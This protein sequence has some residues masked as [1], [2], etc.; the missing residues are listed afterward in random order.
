M[1]AI[2]LTFP[3]GRFHAT[4]WSRHVNEGAPEWPPSPWRLLRSFVAVW[5]RKLDDQLDEATVCTLL[6]KLSAPPVF[7]LPQAVPAHTRHYMPLYDG[8]RTLVFDSFLAIGKEEKILVAWSDVSLESEEAEA[9]S[10]LLENLG[11]LGRAESWCSASFATVEEQQTLP[12]KLPRTCPLGDHEKMPDGCQAIRILCADPE[13]AFKNSAFFDITFKENSKGKRKET[14]KR[15][16]D[17]YSPDWHLCAETLWLHQ[18]RWSQ[19]PG[20][21]WITYARPSDCFKPEP[22]RRKTLRK[23][24]PQPQ[25]LRFALDSAVLPSITDTIRIAENARRALMGLCGKLTEQNGIRGKSA[26]LSGKSEEGERLT[27]HT[28]AYY[29]PTDEDDDGRL[30]HLTVYA[31]QGFG[32]AELRAAQKFLELR[33]RDREES[34]HPLRTL[35]LGWGLEN[36][37][38]PGPL[39]S[40]KIWL[41][42]TPYL[43]TRYPKTRGK[44]KWLGTPADFLLE[45]LK[46]ETARW[47][48]THGI[49]PDA[50]AISPILDAN[51]VFRLPAPSNP[52][53]SPH[54]NRLLRPLQ[55]HRF[56]QKRDDDG[57]RRLSGFFRIEFPEPTTGPIALG[58]SSHFGLGLFTPI[59]L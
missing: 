43:A 22:V 24:Q 39:A 59:T 11:F 23:T 29:L 26:I 6:K 41:S 28:H 56:R 58:H 5:K 42:A 30:D 45:D 19:P 36:E 57:G 12:L 54:P 55:F 34:G 48:A 31:Q 40:S 38:H 52:Q 15:T 44:D 8:K 7:H 51:G 32:D 50:I 13:E 20:S 53:G 47:S 27:D 2:T 16:A 14:Q 49:Q 10:L 17:E 33:D 3:A 1:T 4:P 21:R 9:L 25:V 46:Q 37:F 35:L 18:K